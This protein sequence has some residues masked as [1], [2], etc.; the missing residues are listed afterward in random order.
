VTVSPYPTPPY[1]AGAFC[2]SSCTDPVQPPRKGGQG[3]G[4]L[5]E[6]DPC[7]PGAQGE[8]NFADLLLGEANCKVLV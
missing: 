5:L 7:S 2:D 3:E 1:P 6:G 4:S 8:A